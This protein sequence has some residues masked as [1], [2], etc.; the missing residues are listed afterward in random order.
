MTEIQIAYKAVQRMIE[1]RGVKVKTLD[2]LDPNTGD[3]DGMHIYIDFALDADLALFVLLHLFGHTVQWNLSEELRRLGLNATPGKTDE[4]LRPVY[5]YELDATRYGISLLHE[6]GIWDMDQWVSDW[7]HAD[8]MFLNHF[9]KTGERLHAR[10]LLT[11]GKGAL[12][13]PLEIP[14]F[15][16]QQWPTRFAF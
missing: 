11:P 12:L 3:F 15:S 6:A 7:F 14:S 13:A 9:Y 10:S 4:E 1:L 5:F 8:W 16:P 2:V